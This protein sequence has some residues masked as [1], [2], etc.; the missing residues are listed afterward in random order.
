MN[1]FLLLYEIHVVT[2]DK[3]F[4][5]QIVTLDKIFVLQIVTLDKNVLTKTIYV[6]RRNIYL[7]N[8]S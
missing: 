8:T 2:L 6:Q 3:M 4:V 1:G 5:L 7:K